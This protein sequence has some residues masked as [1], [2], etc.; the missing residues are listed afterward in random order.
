MAIVRFW[1]MKI[2]KQQVQDA[3]TLKEGLK[4]QLAD[5]KA[6]IAQ[7]EQALKGAEKDTLRL[8][9]DI[10]EY[11]E[12]A[13]QLATLREKHSETERTLAKLQSEMI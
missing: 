12:A 2:E 4:D 10:S 1:K 8:E 7:L 13:K 5:C 9:S 11:K 3:N 6:K